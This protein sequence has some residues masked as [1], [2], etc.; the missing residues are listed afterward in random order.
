MNY[1]LH[2]KI[3]TF[4]IVVV[5]KYGIIRKMTEMYLF[6]LNEIIFAYFSMKWASFNPLKVH[7]EQGIGMKD[8]SVKENIIVSGI[9]M[10]TPAHAHSSGSSNSHHC[11]SGWAY[12]GFTKAI[13]HSY[14][15]HLCNS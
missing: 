7:V 14:H 8:C 15:I 9:Q 3:N 1:I 11:N 10:H 4:G 2:F 6:F 5:V 13:V 12:K